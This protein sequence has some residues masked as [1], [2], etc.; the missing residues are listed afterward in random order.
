M[1]PTEFPLT[2]LAFPSLSTLMMASMIGDQSNDAELWLP[3]L[4]AVAVVGISDR[5]DRLKHAFITK[6]FISFILF[7]HEKKDLSADFRVQSYAKKTEYYSFY[8][9]MC[10]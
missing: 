1:T 7:S 2:A 8:E 10:A 5:N 3:L 6:F 9:V 4:T